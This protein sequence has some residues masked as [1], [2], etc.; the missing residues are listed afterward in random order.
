MVF[1]YY[2]DSPMLADEV[3]VMF[4][5]IMLFMRSKI[6]LTVETVKS[7]LECLLSARQS[8][9]CKGSLNSSIHR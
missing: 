1:L 6:N 9:F 2:E 7:T 3:M 4:V 8:L 5:G